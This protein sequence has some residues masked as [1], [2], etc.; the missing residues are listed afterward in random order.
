MKFTLLSLLVGA[1]AAFA[2]ASQKVSTTALQMSDYS[3]EV[4]A[5]PPTGFFDP[6]KLS[7]GISPERFDLYRAAELKHGRVAM[8]AVLGYIAPET[9]RFPGEVAYGL[10][11]EDVPNGLAALDAVPAL[12]WA[13]IVAAIGSVEFAGTLGDFEIG[14]PDFT[15]DV[16]AAR[17]SQEISHGRLAMIAILELLRHDKYDEVGELIRGLP[18][19]YN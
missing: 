9:Y 15:P 7:S 4:G 12:G 16:L 6:L 13:Q 8:M 1:A 11:F 17:Q 5:Q 18:F 14:K 10:K 19:I 2:P 3:G